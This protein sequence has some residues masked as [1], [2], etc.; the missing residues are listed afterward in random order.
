VGAVVDRLDRRIV[1]A[2]VQRL[3]V[4]VELLARDLA[5][6]GVEQA[7]QVVQDPPVGLHGAVEPLARALG[8]AVETALRLV[9][10]GTRGAQIEADPDRQRQP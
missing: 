5:A 2:H 6:V 8:D 7:G 3:D 10:D 9:V 4:T 1:F